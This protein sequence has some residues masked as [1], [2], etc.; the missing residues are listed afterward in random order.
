M[1]QYVTGSIIKKLRES[2]NMTQA[3]LAAKLSVSDKAISK[4]ETAKGYPD[5]TL[6]E[7]LA[8]ALGISTIELFSGND[9]INRN[10]ASHMLRTKL[11]VCPVCGNVIHSV[12]AA[13][14][15]CCGITLPALEAEPA[16]PGHALRVEQVEDE[17]YVTADHPMEKTH[18]ISFLA[19]VSDDG[20]HLVKLYPEGTA[21][22]RFKAGGIRAIYCYCNQ[23]G[24]FLH[25]IRR[26]PQE[27]P[28]A[29]R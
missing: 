8:K 10:R 25:K 23:H 18:F 4:W 21:G 29:A 14:V 26:R 20:F 22:A 9:I 2:R 11:Y 3:E 13:V 28:S 12:G 24:L 5:I 7:P 19:A 6:I 17:Y 16:D 27:A 1:N 15:S